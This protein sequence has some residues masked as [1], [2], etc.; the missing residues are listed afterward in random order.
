MDLRVIL[1]P[2]HVEAVS[3][4][5]LDMLLADADQRLE[6]AVLTSIDQ[7]PA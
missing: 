2:V 1:R 6:A 7:H 5:L 4:Y 3:K